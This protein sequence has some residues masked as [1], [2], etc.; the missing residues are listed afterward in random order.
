[1]SAS[2][3]RIKRKIRQLV[4]MDNTRSR[5]PSDVS[6]IEVGQ[7]DSYNFWHLCMRPLAAKLAKMG[8][9]ERTLAILEANVVRR[10]S[11][12]GRA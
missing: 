4:R 9:K 10:V 1:M 7:D 5:M 6:L 3:R 11:A 8:Q 12:G 2:K